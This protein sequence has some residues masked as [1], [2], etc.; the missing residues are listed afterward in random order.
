M[1][2]SMIILPFCK[3]KKQVNVFNTRSIFMSM[4]NDP[5]FKTGKIIN[6]KIEEKFQEEIFERTGVDVK[7][8]FYYEFYCEKEN[9]FYTQIDLLVRDNDTSNYFIKNNYYQ[10]DYLFLHNIWDLYDKLLLAKRFSE[11]KLKLYPYAEKKRS[12]NIYSMKK[13]ITNYILD[14]LLL[15][16]NREIINQ[17]PL[18][19][20][21]IYN[22]NLNYLCIYKKKRGLKEDIKNENTQ[23]IRKVIF[24]ILKEK[25]FF[26]YF[27][28]NNFEPVFIAKKD[29]PSDQVFGIARENA[30]IPWI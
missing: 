4:Y 14:E 2:I 16:V 27:D 5:I 30:E 12:V 1:L 26:N 24:Q 13:Y 19:D 15:K 23:K 6:S 17:F 9:Y 7:R 8:I 11:K 21:R 18:P 3:I 29:I 10:N 25:D 28:Y 20:K 22:W